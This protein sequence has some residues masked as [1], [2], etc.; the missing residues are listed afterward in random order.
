M[1]Q[2]LGSSNQVSYDVVVIGGGLAGITA[3]IAA[4]RLGSRV[5]LLQ[6]RPV[7]GGNSSSEIRVPIGGADAAGRNRQARE[8][9]IIE[10]L[11]LE[12]GHRE[13]VPVDK[14]NLHSGNKLVWD[15]ILEEWV[16]RE[17]NLA[18]F[19]DS[20]A[21]AVSMNNTNRIS[22]VDVHQGGSNQVFTLVGHVFIDATG[23]GTIATWAGADFM[24]G[25]E[26]HEAYGEDLAPEEP[27][28]NTLGSSIMF[29]IRDAGY[30]VH[31]NAP[32]WA[33][34]YTDCSSLPPHKHILDVGTGFWWIECGGNRD[35]IADNVE[36]RKELLRMAL[37]VLDHIKNHCTIAAQASNYTLDWVAPIVGKRESRR[38]LGDYVLSQ[39]DLTS[40]KLPG[41]RVSYGGWPIDLHPGSGI[42][43][44]SPYSIPFRCLYSSKVENLLLAGRDISAT[45]TA[46]GST[47]V[48]GTCATIGQAV[49]TAAHL[50][51]KYD[52]GARAIYGA[53]IEELQQQ[54]LKD[55]SYIIGLRSNDS[56][57]LA[58]KSEV[59][60]SSSLPL[61]V[62]SAVGFE[63]LDYARGQVCP[64]SHPHIEAIQLYLISDRSTATDVHLELCQV[65]S[66]EDAGSQRKG[67]RS[68]A[69]IAPCSTGWVPFEINVKVEAEKLYRISLH[70]CPGIHWG[71]ASDELVCTLRSRYDDT[72]KT[73][74]PIL[75]RQDE[76]YAKWI[77]DYGTFCFKFI[78]DQQPYGPVNVISGVSRPDVNPHIWISD[79]SQ[80]FPQ[81]L[82]FVFARSV[83]VNSVHLTFDTDLNYHGSPL[84]TAP[85]AACVRDYTLYGF[86]AGAWISI[87]EVDGNY[88]RR[89]IHTLADSILTSKI[90]L[91]VRATNGANT[92]RVYEVRIY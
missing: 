38:V 42:Q 55:D 58:R 28:A 87:V 29:S 24:M 69:R 81:Y 12:F 10:E 21:V 62:T 70:R 36:I 72:T 53:H 9:G 37:G 46:L 67:I 59:S 2:L 11:R 83:R 75:G 32:S 84:L 47:R 79:S 86:E 20:R 4:S 1:K 61:Q 39:N 16:D 64:I 77:P 22:S 14:R 15:I 63:E 66:L 78:P 73:W 76:K 40:G 52:V 50:C 80:G 26:G 35:T 68:Q 23:D 88:Q 19:L 56:Q 48:M 82:D 51:C 3:A 18:L 41:D 25:R 89:R 30:P 31:F 43:A 71:Y 34:K 60:G 45:H 8:T 13:V 7:L 92:A 44:N 33:A 91:E 27:D 90:R 49:G 65:E 85:T 5:A 57:D 6:D 17:A 54:L 74:K